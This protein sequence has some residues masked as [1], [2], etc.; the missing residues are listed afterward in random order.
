MMWFYPYR[1]QNLVLKVL[2]SENFA[3]QGG[4]PKSHVVFK[5][6]GGWKT[7]FA[8]DGWGGV[9]NADFPPTLFLN[10]P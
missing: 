4:L 2:K 1:A 6:G 3:S 7:M 10:G 8:Y 9:K 5:G